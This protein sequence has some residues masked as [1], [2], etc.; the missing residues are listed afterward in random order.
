[1]H[2][3]CHLGLLVLM[4][5]L[6]ACSSC[7]SG[8]EQAETVAGT[9]TEAGTETASDTSA[10][11]LAEAETAT[12]TVTDPDG[13]TGIEAAVEAT[14]VD[15][16]CAALE[17]GS[18]KLTVN[19]EERTL[20]LRL[21]ENARLG[22]PWPV[23]FQ[24]HGLGDTA[25]NFE[26]LM[27]PYVN[28]QM[29]P[30]ILVT[31]EALPV[32]FPTG[33]DWDLLKI[34]DGGKELPFFDTILACLKARWEID[35]DRIYS[36]GFSAGAVMTDLLAATRG[37][38]L[39]AVFTWSG[40]YL[41][42]PENDTGT[43][44]VMADWPPYTTTNRYAQVIA[45]GGEKDVWTVVHFNSFAAA[46]VP[47]LNGMGH[48][49]VVCDHGLGHTVPQALQGAQVLE[50]FFYHPR[51][52]QDSPWASSGLPGSFPQYCTFSPSTER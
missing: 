13:S 6:W 43:V 26:F 45:F 22:G 23:V 32:E 31:P 18:N 9:E 5:T 39:A 52:A 50:F 51:T 19:G 48:D 7:E 12:E 41:D 36:M 29:F 20:L 38:E 30:F 10:E 11:A 14:P 42:D 21:P 28:N 1:M 4:V 37:D 35:D 24:W 16:Q 34:P 17:E 15:P 33:L 44:G 25:K 40:G 27:K 49:L 2:R 47:W 3:V 46:D 8:K